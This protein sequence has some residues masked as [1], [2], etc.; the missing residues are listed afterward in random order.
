[1]KCTTTEIMPKLPRIETKAK[2]LLVGG[3]NAKMGIF[4]F[5]QKLIFAYEKNGRFHT[6]NNNW[7]SW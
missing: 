2:V 3:A 4:D 7:D 1:M 6:K 5:I